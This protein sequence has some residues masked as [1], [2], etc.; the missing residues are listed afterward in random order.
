M[1]TTFILGTDDLYNPDE[2][3]LSLYPLYLELKSTLMAPSPRQAILSAPYAQLSAT[4]TNLEGGTVNASQISIGGNLV[5]DSNG[6]W[7][8]P[9]V[10]TAWNDITGIP[11]DIADGDNDTQL[12]ETQVENYIQNDSIDLASG[13]TLNGDELSPSAPLTHYWT[14]PV[15]MEM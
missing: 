10:A 14:C 9:T 12:T 6:S 3:V 11:S 2:T 4:S 5:I 1:A 13:S 7:V 8:G 15:P